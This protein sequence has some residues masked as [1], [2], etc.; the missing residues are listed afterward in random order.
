MLLGTPT[1]S[2]CVMTVSSPAVTGERCTP[3]T[4]PVKPIRWLPRASRVSHTPGCMVDDLSTSSAAPGDLE[5]VRRFVNT[6]DIE[7]GTD[8]LG[9]P[10]VTAAWLRRE[11]MPVRIDRDGFEA[12][13]ELRE[14]ITDVVSA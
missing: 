14:A 8:E 10:P 5:F 13:I 3:V 9:S 11:G 12:L 2:I 4:L 6:L 1:M 7:A